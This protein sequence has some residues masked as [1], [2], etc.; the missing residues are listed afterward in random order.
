[1]GGGRFDMQTGAT[2]S[3]GLA[4]QYEQSRKL[5]RNCLQ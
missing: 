4:R 3:I 5:P 2:A 1:M